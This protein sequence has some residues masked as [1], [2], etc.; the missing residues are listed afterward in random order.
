MAVQPTQL[1]LR[2]YQVG[3]GDCFLLTF[4]YPPKT[5]D[6]HV[7]IDFGSTGQ[8]R[9]TPKDLM[10][11]IA[12]DIQKVTGGKLH[13]VVATH[14]HK[15]H[16]SGF[17][18]N[19][20]GTAS[21]DIIA[22]LKPKV[23]VQP[24]TEDP[25]AKPDAT[26]AKN[27]QPKAKAL[28]VQSLADMN[29]FSASV[30]EE[31]SQLKGAVGKRLLS[32]LAFLGEDNLKNLSAV[33]NLMT[34]GKKHAYVNYGSKSG[35]EG[36][37]PG[38]KTHVLGPPTIEQSSA[39]RSMRKE[40]AAEFWH[41]QAAA[42]HRF[43]G[44]GKSP[45]PGAETYSAT[46]PFARWFVPRLDSI[47]GDQLLQLV[48]ILDD[49]MNNTSV[50]L[51]FE[52]GDKK[53]LFPGDAQIENWSYA[54]FTAK[55]RKAIQKLLAALNLY[56]VGHHGSLN[57]TPKTLW[58]LFKHKSHSLHDTHRLKTV[59]STMPGKHGSTDRNT[60]VPRRKLVEE[61]K[62]DSDYFSTQ[63]LKGKK[64]RKDIVINI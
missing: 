18:T 26:K 34:M 4:H 49:A 24:W 33:E 55:N 25:K 35:L 37:L 36:V 58:S 53:F 60:E 38:V 39:I 27:A 62:R 16:I 28:F 48:R 40:D 56:K 46:P 45:F 51:L 47:R 2:T 15:D 41:L 64:L 11:Q 20:K 6:R 52:V 54:L 7:L 21:G 5:G 42:G 8:P 12:K 30:L 63:E 23:V 43:T 1:T 61:L 44:Q 29:Q 32:Q 50:I 13:A 14:R 17:A 59:V 10:L 57:A 19:K 9:G 22:S 31:L 3:F